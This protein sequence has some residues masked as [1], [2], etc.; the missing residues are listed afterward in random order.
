MHVADSAPNR[1]VPIVVLAITAS[2]HTPLLVF[3]KRV[4]VSMLANTYDNFMLYT[5]L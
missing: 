2:G 5:I 1:D 3:Y 4:R